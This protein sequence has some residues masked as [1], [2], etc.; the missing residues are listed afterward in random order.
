MLHTIDKHNCKTSKRQSL[1]GADRR[2]GER[3][4]VLLSPRALSFPTSY[5]GVRYWKALKESAESYD[6]LKA[7]GHNVKILCPSS[8]GEGVQEF[9]KFMFGSDLENIRPGST[10]R[11]R[12]DDYW[13]SQFAIMWPRD[14]FQ[15]YGDLIFAESD[16]KH[17]TRKMLTALGF[18]SSIVIEKSALG[19]GGLVVR[20]R[21]TLIISEAARARGIRR[22][23]L[24]SLRN[25]G[26]S[27]HFLPVDN[28]FDLGNLS[29]RRRKDPNDHIDTEFGLVFSKG[30]N[31][32]ACVNPHYYGMF[33]EQVDRLIKEIDA[34]LY[35]APEN[36]LGVNFISL[37][38]GKAIVSD[39]CPQIV[40]FLER[41]LGTENVTTLK[42][43]P[44]ICLRG[45]GLRCMS[46][47]IE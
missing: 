38:D 28:D 12:V 32:L 5:P 41:G 25:R 37:P 44:G 8:E 33:R 3:P 22:G 46:N 40:A 1:H 47:V 43:N 42:V 6:L 20:S 24:G 11:L 39:L 9:L 10:L 30:G 17:E 13:M 4:T 18:P 36:T 26:Y 27:I 29:L 45:G 16:S 31:A 34:L 35:V 19:E 23:E 15:I 14:R 21:K 2:K 7:K